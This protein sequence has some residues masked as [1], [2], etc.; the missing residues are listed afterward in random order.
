MCCTAAP[1]SVIK[2]SRMQRYHILIWLCI[3]IVCFNLRLLA[4]LSHCTYSL[5]FVLAT[6]DVSYS[7]LLYFY[8]TNQSNYGIFRNVHICLITTALICSNIFF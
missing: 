4:F 2:F 8:I 3:Y 6:L 7:V 1:L 5:R